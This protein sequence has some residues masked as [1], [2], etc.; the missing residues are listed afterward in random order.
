MLSSTAV[1]PWPTVPVG[2]GPGVGAAGVVGTGAAGGLLVIEKVVPGDA[3]VVVVAVVSEAGSAPGVAAGAALVTGGTAALPP[4]IA[5]VPGGGVDN[6][7]P[8][9]SVAVR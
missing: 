6:K 4:S 3:G 8:T 1:I 9:T 7:S 5:G 2:A